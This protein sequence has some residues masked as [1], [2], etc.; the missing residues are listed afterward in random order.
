LAIS[1]LRWHTAWSTARAEIFRLF[2]VAELEA[3]CSRWKRRRGAARQ[4][5][6]PSKDDVG[7]DGGIA[8]NRDL[9]GWTLD[10]R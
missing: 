2:T 1:V 7:F 4:A 5:A 3:S 9:A 8:E 10:D 6:P